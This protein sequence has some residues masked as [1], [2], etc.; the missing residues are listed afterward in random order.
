MEFVKG[1]I[2][3][4]LSAGLVACSSM[5]P[6][7]KAQRAEESW[8]KYRDIEGVEREATFVPRAASELQTDDS[9]L[10]LGTVLQ[11]VSEGK[12]IHRHRLGELYNKTDTHEQQFMILVKYGEKSLNPNR[13]EEMAELMKA[14]AFDF[15]Q[16]GNY[17]I[18]HA[19]F[20]APRAMCKDI[21]TRAG[22]KL[23][24][25]VN[26]YQEQDPAQYYSILLKH[27]ISLKK[28][29]SYNVRYRPYFS[30]SE[31]VTAL[32]LQDLDNLYGQDLAT[33]EVVDKSLLLLGDICGRRVLP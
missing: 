18:L 30:A 27:H 16:F 5:K 13:A 8:L 29:L 22:V 3:L 28:P 23:E 21:R 1:I 14:D 10:P 26:Y 4:A 20:Q 33:M 9:A 19:R 24:M 15:Y 12:V 32:G 31:Q 17:R 7:G 6:Q 2:C 25:A 11:K